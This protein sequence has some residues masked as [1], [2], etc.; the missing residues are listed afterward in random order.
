MHQEDFTLAM[1]QRLLHRYILFRNDKRV[2]N[3]TFSPGRA[4]ER[5]YAAYGIYMAF[6]YTDINTEDPSTLIVLDSDSD[7]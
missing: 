1:E 3:E 2:V 6:S 4:P 5:S 7:N